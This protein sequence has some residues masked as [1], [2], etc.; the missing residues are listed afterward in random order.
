MQGK[1]RSYPRGSYTER[2]WKRVDVRGLGECWPW[3]GH[4]RGDGYGQ[5]RRGAHVE[6]P[7]YVMAH[8]AAYESAV[9]PVP[10]GHDVHHRCENRPCCNPAH[11]RPLAHAEHAARHES[12]GRFQRA[13]TH[14]P[15]R[16][17]YDAVNTLHYRGRRYCR[18]CQRAR[19]ERAGRPRK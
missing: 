2:V 6:G 16:H 18:A 12:A 9:G 4:L 19:R 11:L 17:P 7:V 5:L 15:Q 14:C 1:G 3:R 8:V 10:E 13:K